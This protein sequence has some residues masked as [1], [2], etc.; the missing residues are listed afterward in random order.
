MMVMM[1]VMTMEL[2]VK[3][4]NFHTD[5]IWATGNGDGDNNDYMTSNIMT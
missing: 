2:V 5:P 1:M 4:H 3:Y